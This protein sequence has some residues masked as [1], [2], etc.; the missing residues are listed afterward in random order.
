MPASP[1][2]LHSR[3]L[4]QREITRFRKNRIFS[5][6]PSRQRRSWFP[7]S[8]RVVLLGPFGE[9]LTTPTGLA[10]EMPFR[11]STKYQDAETGLYSYIFRPY[12]PLTGRWLSRDPIEE[13]GGVNLY[14]FVENDGIDGIDALG[15]WKRKKTVTASVAI[16]EAENGD[17]IAGLAKKRG[18]TPNQW[19]KWSTVI[20]GKAPKDEND[21][22]WDVYD[23]K[24]REKC[25]FEIAV[26]NTVV[27]Y[28]GGALGAAG[29]VWTLWYKNV[30]KLKFQGYLV[31]EMKFRPSSTKIHRYTSGGK[32]YSYKERVQN[33]PDNELGI[34]AQRYWDAKHLQG[35]Y[36]W[37][38]GGPR[39]IGGDNGWGKAEDGAALL[40][41]AMSPRYDLGLVWVRSCDS[42][43][44]APF[45]VGP[46][47][48]Y[49]GGVTGLLVPIIPGGGI[50]FP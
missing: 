22:I 5:N 45:L 17:T 16:F 25:P 23:Q 47:T 18:L 26:P 8:R 32:R 15:L 40:Y 29:R 21:R 7:A 30:A 44:C 2:P 27:A 4:R 28:W 6:R 13:D 41:E 31:A 35:I 49:K 19:K 36:F 42:N 37:G 33:T 46:N 20:A 24:T 11:F 50:V 10:A 39:D 34:I 48:D 12:D 9:P 43:Y 3:L 1:T 14:G 38:H